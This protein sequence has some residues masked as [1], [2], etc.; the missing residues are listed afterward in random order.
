MT[1]AEFRA[2]ARV[3]AALEVDENSSAQCFEGPGRL[4]GDGLVIEGTAE[5]GYC[6][7]IGSDSEMGALVDL[8]AKLYQWAIDQGYL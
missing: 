3:V 7:T 5:A 2:T 8:E 1:L 6:L 4:Y